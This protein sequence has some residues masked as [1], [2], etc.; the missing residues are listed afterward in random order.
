M[1][2][3]AVAPNLAAYAREEDAATFEAALRHGIG[4]DGK[5]LYSMPSYNFVR[6]RDEDV[7]AIYAYLGSIPVVR[8]ELPSPVLPWQVRL[9][10]AKGDDAAIPAFLDRVP[11]LH[12]SGDSDQAIARGEYIAMTTCNE[13]HGFSLRADV[14]WDDETAPDLLIVRAYDKAAFLHLMRT[15]KAVGGRELEM[16]SG[17]AR[18]RFAHFTDMEI[19]DL[20]RFLTDMSARASGSL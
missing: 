14:P 10:M 8:K 20:Y 3:S 17:V 2:G 15:G 13:C 7:A 1:W 16:M 12:R 18:G 4:R 5:A 9:E 19:D 6:M 11:P